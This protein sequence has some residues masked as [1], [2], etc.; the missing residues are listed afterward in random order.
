MSSISNRLSKLE[1]E[2]LEASIRKAR[3]LGDLTDQELL[4]IILAEEGVEISR[5][6]IEAQMPRFLETGEVPGMRGLTIEDLVAG[7]NEKGAQQ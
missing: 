3:P 7:K 4:E 2:Q 1:R 5:K 6:D